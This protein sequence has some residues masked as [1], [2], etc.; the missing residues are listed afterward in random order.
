MASLAPS[1]VIYIA[2]ALEVLRRKQHSP[3]AQEV[4]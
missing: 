3:E 2:K 4:D 1:D